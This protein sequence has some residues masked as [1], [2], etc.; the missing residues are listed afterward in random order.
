MNYQVKLCENNEIPLP[1]D[2]CSE[3]DIKI[4]D[5]LFCKVVGKSSKLVITK[6]S[7]QTL[8]DADIASAGNLTRVISLPSSN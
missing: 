5:I 1:D 3:L 7:N 6:H 8:S 2:L 4:G